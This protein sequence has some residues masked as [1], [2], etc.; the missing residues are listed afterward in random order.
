MNDRE[1]LALLSLLAKYAA[2][3]GRYCDGD[4]TVKELADDLAGAMDEAR[5]VAES[6]DL[7]D[8]V[9]DGLNAA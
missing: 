8:K 5:H 4:I 1:S 7:R 9:Y 2:E 3:Y 6:E